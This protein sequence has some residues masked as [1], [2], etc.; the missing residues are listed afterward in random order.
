MTLLIKSFGL[1]GGRVGK[2]MGRGGKERGGG[3]NIQLGYNCFSG[4]PFTIHGGSEVG[5]NGG[6]E[7]EGE[8][9]REE[10]KKEG[11]VGGRGRL[12]RYLQII[13]VFH[14]FSSRSLPC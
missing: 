2:R 7:G 10:G 6:R 12:S 4:L 14:I 13:L 8:R 11:R 5:R 1:A 9:R 3:T